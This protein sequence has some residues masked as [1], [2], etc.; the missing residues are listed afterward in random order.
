MRPTQLAYKR[1]DATEARDLMDTLC[2]Q[3][4]HYRLS[5]HL[6]VS[7]SRF[8]CPSFAFETRV[9]ARALGSALEGAP[10]LQARLVAALSPMDE[11]HK[12]EHSQELAA[13]VVEALLTLCHEG[14]P[15]V[16]TVEIAELVNAIL[17]GRHERLE[18]S[19]KKVGA[20]LRQQLGLYAGRKS[21]GYTLLLDSS[22]RRRIHR[23]SA[24]Y[25]V[26][27]GWQEGCDDCATENDQGVVSEQ[28]CGK[29]EGQPVHDAPIDGN[30]HNVHD[31]HHVHEAAGEAKQ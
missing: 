13:I 2:P 15:E 8:D 20:I 14:K 3:L 22:T 27:S 4:L 23:L 28:S 19:A 7:G 21:A 1:I 24:T 29:L 17:V 30:V 18:I 6:Q 11:Q 5:H 10:Q 9:L 26:L 16:L 25:A 12:V 31:V